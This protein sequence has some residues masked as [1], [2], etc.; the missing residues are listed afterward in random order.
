[1][2]SIGYSDI[3]AHIKQ[4]NFLLAKLNEIAYRIQDNSLDLQG[5]RDFL[6]S[7]LTGHIA[8]SDT[9]LVSYINAK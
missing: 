7:W 6:S 2:R 3:S 4:H 8:S 1:M 9:K 5:M